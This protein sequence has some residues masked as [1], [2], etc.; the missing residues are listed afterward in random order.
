VRA[1]V[2]AGVPIIEETP[3]EGRLERLFLEPR[4][5]APPAPPAGVA[6]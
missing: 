5:G 1:L 3:E 4:A 2:G 6:S